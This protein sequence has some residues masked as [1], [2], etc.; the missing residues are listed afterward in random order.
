MTY[1]FVVIGVSVINA[2]ANKKVSY[3]ELLLTNS[4]ILG[5]LWILEK[6]LLLKQEHCFN[7]IYENIENVKLFS[8]EELIADLKERTGRDIKRFEIKK[9]DYMRD[10]VDLT[11][12]YN[13]NGRENHEEK[14]NQ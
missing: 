4:V 7:L 5:I 2:L 8:D 12:Y 14:K 13:V 11:L 6:R 10:V 3:A 1:L 9:M